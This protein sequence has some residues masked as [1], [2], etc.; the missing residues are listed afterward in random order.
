MAPNLLDSLL[1]S[2]KMDEHLVR[3]LP[4]RLPALEGFIQHCE[5]ML[6]T[7]MVRALSASTRRLCANNPPALQHCELVDY[8]RE[9]GH[10]PRTQIEGLK[11]KLRHPSLKHRAT[12][13]YGTLYDVLCRF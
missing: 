2:R 10:P 8:M 13:A 5:L 12:Q 1:M 3:Y 9:G 4:S 6:N 11:F 7:H